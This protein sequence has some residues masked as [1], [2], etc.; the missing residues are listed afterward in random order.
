VSDESSVDHDSHKN[1]TSSINVQMR[2]ASVVE[3]GS[4]A[5]FEPIPVQVPRQQI[6]HTPI[7]Q[8]QYP[9]FSSSACASSIGMVS[10]RLSSA[11]SMKWDD[12]AIS[13][14]VMMGGYHTFPPSSAVAPRPVS[15]TADQVLD[16]AVD[17]LFSNTDVV[18]EDVAN[19]DDFWDP[20]AFG[21]A[22]EVGQI[23]ND[24]QLG[25]LLETFLDQY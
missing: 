6:F 11:S 8:Q 13:S 5:P 4:I 21:E 23:E 3:F 24:L 16:D 1:G 9:M 18:S 14:T 17:E 20:A 15:S 22:D 12:L 19:L 25:N 10:P 2:P 7:Q